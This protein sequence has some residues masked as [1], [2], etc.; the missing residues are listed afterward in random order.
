MPCGT[1]E[2]LP[3]VHQRNSKTDGFFPKAN[4]RILEDELTRFSPAT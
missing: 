4:P 3:F 1:A 2:A